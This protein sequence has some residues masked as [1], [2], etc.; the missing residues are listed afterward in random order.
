M[1]S[2]VFAVNE[3]DVQSQCHVLVDLSWGHVCLPAA[4]YVDDVIYQSEK[5]TSMYAH[6]FFFARGTIIS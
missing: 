2:N 6:L 1:R 3:L 5:E 4:A